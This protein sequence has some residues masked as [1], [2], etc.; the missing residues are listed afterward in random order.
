MNRLKICT[1]THDVSSSFVLSYSCF[2]LFLQPEGDRLPLSFI[3]FAAARKT[4][5]LRTGCVCNPGGVSAIT[6]LRD[7][8][9]SD[10]HE[11]MK[12]AE[13]EE[14]LGYESGIVRISFGLASNLEDAWNVAQFIYLMGRT[15]AREELWEEYQASRELRGR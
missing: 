8:M 6:G 7:A 4:I 14:Q 11:G 15:A 3:D 2:I 13:W 1:C 12:K 9:Q 5:S 10:L